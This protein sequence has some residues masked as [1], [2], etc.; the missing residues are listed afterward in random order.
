LSTE[1]LIANA[2][3]YAVSPA[4]ETAWASLFEAAGRR[5]QVDWHY[6]PHPAPAPLGA[7][8]SRQDLGAAF[9]CGLPWC[10]RATTLTPLAAPVPDGARYRSR[11]CYFTEFV[12]RTQAPFATLDDSFGGRL[13]HML[14]ESHSGYNLPRDHLR[15][16]LP[17]GAAAVYRPCATSTATPGQVVR[18][19]LEGDAEV[20]VV[21]SYVLDLLRAWDPQTAQ[22][23][24]TLEQTAGSPNPFLV[25]SA[26]VDPMQREA[27]GAALRGLHLDPSG[28]R[29]LAA[30]RLLRFD[31]VDPAAYQ[32]LVAQREACDAAGFPLTGAAT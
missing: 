1:T 27:I 5:A 31:P 28:R 16:R 9:I 8:W 25:A 24:R 20:G 22:G 32:A 26:M 21:D 10:S 19:V 17:P 23:L 18:A 30:L 15:R 7:L 14:P 4:A 12:C 2:R 3:M 13:A 29:L 11:P 6:L